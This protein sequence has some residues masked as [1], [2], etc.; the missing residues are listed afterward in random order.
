[1][2]GGPSIKCPCCSQALF[3][4]VAVSPHVA[5]LSRDSPKIGNDLKGYFMKCPHCMKRIPFMRITAPTGGIG[6]ELDPK[7]AC[8]DI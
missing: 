3:R 7:Q 4:V 5:A 6:F 1:M 2:A 8:S